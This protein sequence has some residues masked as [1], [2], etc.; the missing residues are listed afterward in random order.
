MNNNN[1]LSQI[2]LDANATTPVLPQAANA[3]MTAMEHL[4]GNPS[5]SHITGLR[6]KNLMEQTRAKAKQIIGSAN[7]K[8]IFTSG[9]TE[10]IQT[11]ILSALVSARTRL[12]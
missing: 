9:A 6:A 11:A 8:I 1:N 12:V 2:Y 5:S 3:A 7:G 10:G 4:F